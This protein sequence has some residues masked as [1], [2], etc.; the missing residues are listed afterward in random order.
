MYYLRHGDKR[1][2]FKMWVARVFLD[3]IKNELKHLNGFENTALLV[4]SV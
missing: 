3:M 2:L 1:V 4:F